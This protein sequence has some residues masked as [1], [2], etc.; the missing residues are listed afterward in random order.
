MSGRRSFGRK[1]L[2]RSIAYIDAG[3]FAKYG[4]D[5]ERSPVVIAG[6]SALILTGM[7]SRTT[8]HD[9][10]ILDCPPEAME[11][12][13]LD[14]LANLDVNVYINNVPYNYE[15]RLVTVV[16]GASL[17]FK[18][19][20]REDMAVM[21]LYGYAFR[22]NDRQDLESEAFLDGLDWNLLD[23]LIY[24][25]DE[26]YASQTSS[27]TYERLVDSYGDYRRS[28]DPRMSGEGLEEDIRKRHEVTHQRAVVGRLTEGNYLAGGSPDKLTVVRYTWG[29]ATIFMVPADEVQSDVTLEEI[30]KDT[31]GIRLSQVDLVK[32]VDSGTIQKVA[33]ST[34]AVALIPKPSYPLGQD[35]RGA[36][37][38]D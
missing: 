1:D 26:A 22:G 6:G 28:Y 19:L 29:G 34:M 2:L 31:D 8:T 4:T 33:P 14:G 24:G 5:S 15:D 21:K 23:E 10:D 36:E 18:V 13:S 30:C 16:P 35:L 11:A 17:S 3:T 9:M 12:I 38:A 20:S 37:T 32:M 27:T 7:T 25:A